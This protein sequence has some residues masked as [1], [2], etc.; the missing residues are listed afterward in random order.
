M[1]SSCSFTPG[2]DSQ[3]PFLQEGPW[4]PGPVWKVH[5]NIF[6]KYHHTGSQSFSES[7]DLR[8]YFIEV[9]VNYFPA[10]INHRNMKTCSRTRYISARIY[11]RGN[12]LRPMT[13]LALRPF[14]PYLRSYSTHRLGSFVDPTA[15][16]DATQQENCNV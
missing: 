8:F 3:Y 9:N 5:I 15:G 4:A 6:T 10:L 16:L 13:C 14:T 1:P 11:D 12:S 7:S 2:N